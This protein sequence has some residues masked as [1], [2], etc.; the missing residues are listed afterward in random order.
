[1]G[2]GLVGWLGWAAAASVPPGCMLRGAGAAS[3]LFAHISPDLSASAAPSLPSVPYP[4]LGENTLA[5]SDV[6]VIAPN[7]DGVPCLMCRAADT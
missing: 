4:L 7:E 3:H 6:C 2:G 5:L 1:M